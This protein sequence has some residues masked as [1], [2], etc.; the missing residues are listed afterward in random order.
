MIQ[1]LLK[2]TEEIMVDT[3]YDVEQLQSNLKKDADEQNYV[4]KSFSFEKK[5]RKMKDEEDEEYFK[6]K[7]VK[8]FNSEKYPDLPLR[9]ILYTGFGSEGTETDLD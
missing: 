4:I 5:A 8:L 9:K 7:V 1:Y 3:E 6:C 2:T